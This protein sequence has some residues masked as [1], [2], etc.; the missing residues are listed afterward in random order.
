MS[1]PTIYMGLP[2]PTPFGDAG[3]WANEIVTCNNGFDTLA[4]ASVPATVTTTGSLAV[5]N[6][7]ALIEADATAGAIVLTLPD[8][9]IPA[10]KGRRYSIVK[11]DSTVNTVTVQ[12]F[13]ISQ[14]IS[15]AATATLSAQWTIL[16]VVSDGAKWIN[17]DP[18][19]VFVTPFSVSIGGTGVSTLALNGVLYGNGTSPVQVTAVGG[20][21][22]V[23]TGTGVAPAFSATPTVTSITTT[24]SSSL[25][26]ATTSAAF[27]PSTAGGTTLGTLALPFSSV[28][29][30]AAGTNNFQITGTA[31]ATRVFTLPDANSNSVQPSTAPANQFANAISASGVVSY[32]QPSFSNISGTAT[33]G[34]G[35]TGDT[36]FT[37][38]GVLYGNTTS[39]VQ[40][41][42]QGAANSVLTANAG[43]PTFSATPTVTS[44][45]T[46]AGAVVGTTI[47]SYNGS[48]TAGNGVAAI[49]AATSQKSE[50]GADASVLS[51]TPPAV[52]GS[53]RVRFVMS[54]SAA[55]AATLG[56][57][58]TYTDSNGNAQ[59]PTNLALNQTGSAPAA[60]TFT[61]SSA[62][63]YYGAVD[64]DINN[65]AT[66]IVVKLTFS[67][68]SFAAKVSSTIARII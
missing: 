35:G 49:L 48:S 34:Q 30:G 24:A 5:Y 25:A 42:A 32:A 6:G 68:T 51:F 61:T 23:L 46:T 56:W 58:I 10:N 21:N 22:T 38:N 14:T 1:T 66:A 44:V 20:V 47:T 19:S 12:G 31:T 8:A 33:V 43:A 9:T 36:T 27:T 52:A 41:T 28:Y 11:V 15:G 2:N 54:V 40:V 65:S 16:H 64:I 26:G 17:S 62:G 13:N 3:T 60:L 4:V 53:Y 45:T 29:V 50:T 39:A 59:T 57:T 67:G 7:S 63:N 37:L 18:E 55:N